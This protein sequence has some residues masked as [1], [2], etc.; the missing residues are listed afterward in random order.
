METFVIVYCVGFLITAM[1]T[2]FWL[3]KKPI[4]KLLVAVL[5]CSVFWPWFVNLIIGW[6]L[7][8]VIDWIWFKPHV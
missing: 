4:P 1:I 5:L 6:N 8:K 2:C 7:G 3:R